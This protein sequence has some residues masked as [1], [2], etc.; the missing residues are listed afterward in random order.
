MARDIR[1]ELGGV[2]VPVLFALSRGKHESFL[3]FG[4]SELT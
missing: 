4:H 2:H 3:F 1:M